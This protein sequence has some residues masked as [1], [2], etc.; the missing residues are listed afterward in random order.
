MELGIIVL[1]N[2]LQVEEESAAEKESTVPAAERSAQQAETKTP[3]S[4]ILSSLLQVKYI[5]SAVKDLSRKRG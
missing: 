5:N 1:V 2:L 3:S 4:P